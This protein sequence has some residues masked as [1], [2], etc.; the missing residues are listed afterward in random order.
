[1]PS[2]TLHSPTQPHFDSLSP[3]KLQNIRHVAAG[4]GPSNYSHHLGLQGRLSL[5]GGNGFKSALDKS[6]SVGM[7]SQEGIQLLPSCSTCVMETD[8][9]LGTA[10]PGR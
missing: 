10:C 6:F 7:A 5:A 9:M 2:C 1:M 8:E 3:R 4:P